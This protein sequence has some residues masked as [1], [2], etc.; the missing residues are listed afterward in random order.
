MTQ[1]QTVKG[2]SYDFERL[3]LLTTV[4]I[5]NMHL[6]NI[7]SSSFK[8]VPPFFLLI[9]FIFA[10]FFFSF[11]FFSSLPPTTFFLVSQTLFLSKLIRYLYRRAVKHIKARICQEYSLEISSVHFKLSIQNEAA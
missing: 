3:L 2:R 6:F 11:S 10:Y 1:T 7:H 8:H 5:N 4:T 9:S